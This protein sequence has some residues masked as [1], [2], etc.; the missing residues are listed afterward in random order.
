MELFRE[1]QLLSSDYLRQ[2]ALYNIQDLV[3][4]FLTEE[5]GLERE[6]TLTQ[7]AVSLQLC[8]D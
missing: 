5:V 1:L 8:I 6:T 2:R 7:A 4:K 3:T